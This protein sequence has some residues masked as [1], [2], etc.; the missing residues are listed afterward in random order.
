M[1]QYQKQVGCRKG[2]KMIKIYRIY[3]VEEDKQQN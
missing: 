2:R 3:R 1:V